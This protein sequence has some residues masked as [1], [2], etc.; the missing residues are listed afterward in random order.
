MEEIIRHL[1][2]VDPWLVY[3]IVFSIAFIE[4]VFP[5]S[6]SDMVVVFAGALVGMG[7]A[8]FL[9]T[10]ACS[11]AGSTAGFMV[12]Y[13]VGGWFGTKILERGR[14]KFLPIDAIRKVEGWFARYGY[15]IIVANRF[16]SGTRAVVS[17]FAGMSRLKLAPTTL[18]SAISALLWNIILVGAGYYLGHHWERIG[19]YLSTYSQIV[20][21]I[22]VVALLV[23]LV[24]FFYKRTNGRKAQ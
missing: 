8:G 5:P 14:I 11:T 13:G 3:L 20:T 15:G 18:L 22:V 7:R 10:L 6:P 24:R 21:G 2:T 17:F 16:L 19:F 1:Q 12:M 4:N 9:T 23:W